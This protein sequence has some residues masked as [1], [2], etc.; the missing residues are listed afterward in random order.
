MIRFLVPALLALAL[1]A[2]AQAHGSNDQVREYLKRELPTYG[3]RDADV[4]GLTKAQVMHIYHLL[5]SGRSAGDVQG[6]VGAILGDSILD[7]FKK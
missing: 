5:H 6:N 1:S 4:D 7:L 2:Q 3:F